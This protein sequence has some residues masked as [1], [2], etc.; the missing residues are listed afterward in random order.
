MARVQEQIQDSLPAFFS[1]HELNGSPVR[2]SRS[3]HLAFAFDP[4]Q[5]RLLV[6]APHILDRRPV[7][8]FEADNLAILERALDGLRELRAGEA[9]V[10]SLRP[11]IVA[12]EKD[13]LFSPSREWSTLTRYRVARHVRAADARKALASDIQAQLRLREFPEAEVTP[14]ECEGIAGK[15]LE[16]A[17][18]LKF[19]VAVPGPVLLGRNRFLGGGMFAG[20]PM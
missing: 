19:K 5:T 7:T 4:A 6:I 10:L 9:G 12:V 8:L 17:A 3:S 2:T 15:G 13:P 18:M 1:G 11:A 14:I 16:G 20:K